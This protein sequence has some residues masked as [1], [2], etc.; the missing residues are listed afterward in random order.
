VSTGPADR[1]TVTRPDP[2]KTSEAYALL[3]EELQGMGIATQDAADIYT[4]I[5]GGL[6]NQ[7]LANDPG[8]GRWRRLVPRVIT[9]F[10]DD[11]GLPPAAVT[12]NPEEDR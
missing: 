2:A 12:T 6:V 11:L 7:Q 9:M 1:P 3:M 5:T 4:A 10:A 8:G